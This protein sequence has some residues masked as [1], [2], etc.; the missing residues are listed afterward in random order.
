MERFLDHGRLERFSITGL[1]E[2][3]PGRSGLQAGF[4]P[5][6]PHIIR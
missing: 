6:L 4:S 5:M 1:V 2:T 3:F